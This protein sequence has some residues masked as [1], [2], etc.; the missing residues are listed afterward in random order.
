MRMKSALLILLGTGFFSQAFTFQ[1]FA[2][3]YN[4]YI[5][6][7]NSK[8]PKD[9][10]QIPNESTFG[11]TAIQLLANKGVQITDQEVTPLRIVI[12]FQDA[13]SPFQFC[14]LRLYKDE[15]TIRIQDPT[16][17]QTYYEEVILKRV[18]PRSSKALLKQIVSKFQLP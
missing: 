16:T 14:E 12:M 18:Y 11:K 4:L 2:N 1:A 6:H 3:P 13:C 7:C 5:S 10:I 8:V 17:F 15:A 9:C